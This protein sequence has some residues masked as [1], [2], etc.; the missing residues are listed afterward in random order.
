[1]K[2]CCYWRATIANIL[3]QQYKIVLTGKFTNLEARR[4]RMKKETGKILIYGYA[5]KASSK[6]VSI[7]TVNAVGEMAAFNGMW[8]LGL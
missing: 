8:A 6:G 5:R 4:K 3:A 7:L 2:Y 1:M